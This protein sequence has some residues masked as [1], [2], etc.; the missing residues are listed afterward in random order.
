MLT[1]LRTAY[2]LAM[3]SS[4]PAWRDSDESASHRCTEADMADSVQ[5]QDS[6][7]CESTVFT[8]S[9]TSSLPEYLHLHSFRVFALGILLPEPGF[10]T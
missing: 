1:L 8:F 10:I 6:G 2:K 4:F 7:Q 5:A 3:R 9:G